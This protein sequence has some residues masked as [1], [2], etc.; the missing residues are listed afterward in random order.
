[1]KLSEEGDG[2]PKEAV[3][4]LDKKR[5]KNLLNFAVQAVRIYLS[6]VWD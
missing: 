1:M 6:Q 2:D 4:T 5:L 3:D